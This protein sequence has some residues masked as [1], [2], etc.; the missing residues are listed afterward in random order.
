MVSRLTPALNWAPDGCVLRQVTL[1][2]LQGSRGRVYLAEPELQR[3]RQRLGQLGIFP[4]IRTLRGMTELGL[5]RREWVWGDRHGADEWM[6]HEEP[7]RKVKCA[8]TRRVG[9]EGYVG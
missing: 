8:G 1:R 4:D 7:M 3:S 6:D 2:L 9:Y 5:I